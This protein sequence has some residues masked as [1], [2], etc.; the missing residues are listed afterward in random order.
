MVRND[1]ISA[2][3]DGNLDLVRQILASGPEKIALTTDMGMTALHRAAQF[4][5]EEV[6]QVLLEAGMRPG[7]RDRRGKSPL[8]DAATGGPRSLF[9][10]HLL[11][12]A[13]CPID[14]KDVYGETPLMDAITYSNV[15]AVAYLLAHGA[16]VSTRN[17]RGQDV[18]D[19]VDFQID[20]IEP[21]ENS[22]ATHQLDDLRVIKLFLKDACET[23]KETQY[24]LQ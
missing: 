19:I 15:A 1:L 8:H 18:L 17:R 5:N 11:I 7:I 13:G 2:S 20:G 12:R 14:G 24:S 9:C 21:L 16:T 22:S 3:E 23:S 4:G 6:V 10:V